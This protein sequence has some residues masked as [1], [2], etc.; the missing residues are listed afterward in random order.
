MPDEHQNNDLTH[1]IELL[2]DDIAAD[3]G[4]EPRFFRG[5]VEDVLVA[6]SGRGIEPTAIRKALEV[7]AQQ[8]SERSNGKTC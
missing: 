7:R 2:S 5:S 8:I 3:Y 6:L 1:L 4:L